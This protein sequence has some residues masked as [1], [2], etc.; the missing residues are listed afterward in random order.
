MPRSRAIFTKVFGLAERSLGAAF[1]LDFHAA[2][3]A[4]VFDADVLAA[5]ARREQAS[6]QVGRGMI[7]GRPS[8]SR[9]PRVLT[10]GK[11]PCR[12]LRRPRPSSARSPTST[13]GCM[14]RTCATPWRGRRGRALLH[15]LV[16]VGKADALVQRVPLRAG[17]VW[18]AGSRRRGRQ[19]AGILLMHGWTAASSAYYA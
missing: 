8:A 13:R 6:M 2:S 16:P 17:R 18:R 3:D 7:S 12:A 1:L 10:M 19:G 11:M 9:M 14:R 15:A 5:R 4:G